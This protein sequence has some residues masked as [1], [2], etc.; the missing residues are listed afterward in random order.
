M[1]PSGCLEL[2][3]VAGGRIRRMT[4]SRAYIFERYWCAQTTVPEFA[5]AVYP[6]SPPRQLLLCMKRSSRSLLPRPPRFRLSSFVAASPQR[7]RVDAARYHI[8]LSEA[9]CPRCAHH[10]GFASAAEPK[11]STFPSISI[12]DA[13]HGGWG[14]P[15]AARA[16]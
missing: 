6:A 13:L 1:K 5:F 12:L 4:G 2:R 10:E 7:P 15:T 11:S 16:S 8:T 14:R 9:E 3:A